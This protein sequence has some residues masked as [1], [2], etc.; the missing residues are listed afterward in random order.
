MNT[1]NETAEREN[2]ALVPQ[3]SKHRLN[4]TKLD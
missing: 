1:N 3:E 4:A 2:T